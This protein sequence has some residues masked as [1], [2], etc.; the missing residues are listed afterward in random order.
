MVDCLAGGAAESHVPGGAVRC[1][2]C[3]ADSR[4][5]LASATVIGSKRWFRVADTYGV[6]IAPD[7]DPVPGLAAAVAIDMMTHD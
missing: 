2:G 7:Q 3:S 4:R 1:V 6:E 5:H